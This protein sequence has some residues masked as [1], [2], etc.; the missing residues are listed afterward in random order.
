MGS[1]VGAVTTK[2]WVAEVAGEGA[3]AVQEEAAK[4]ESEEKDA[5]EKAPKSSQH[6]SCIQVVLKRGCGDPPIH[7]NYHVSYKVASAGKRNARKGPQRP[8]ASRK[9]GPPF[10]LAASES[11]SP[12][13]KP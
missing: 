4:G 10:L 8:A 12:H 7:G 2:L 11:G 1:W 3:E 9:S 6:S 5:E 13:P